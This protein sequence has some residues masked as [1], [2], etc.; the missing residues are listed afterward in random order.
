MSRAVL[1]PVGCRLITIHVL[2]LYEQ[3]YQIKIKN[4]K[5]TKTMLT[6]MHPSLCRYLASESALFL[7]R[8]PRVYGSLFRSSRDNLG[9]SQGLS[10]QVACS[11][12]CLRRQQ[13]RCSR[14]RSSQETWTHRDIVETDIPSHIQGCWRQQARVIQFRL[15]A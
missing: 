13:R 8:R 11:H 9:H 1:L 6:V 10:E 7:C 4:R 5:P 12:S 14:R 3:G 2:N 15:D